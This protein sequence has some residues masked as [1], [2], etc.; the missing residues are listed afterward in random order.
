MIGGAKAGLKGITPSGYKDHGNGFRVSD[1]SFTEL[2]SSS[3]K[4]DL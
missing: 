3:G 1:N 4:L 2:F